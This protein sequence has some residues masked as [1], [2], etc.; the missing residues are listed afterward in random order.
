MYF[1][2]RYSRDPK[3]PEPITAHWDIRIEIEPFLK[4]FRDD[5]TPA[6][7]AKLRDDI[8]M[9][10]THFAWLIYD[11]PEDAGH[12]KAIFEKRARTLKAFE[13]AVSRELEN[14]RQV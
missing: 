3:R 1:D 2:Y 11:M 12:I 6:N 14:I 13:D 10:S 4:F 7:Y 8:G 5:P 9:D